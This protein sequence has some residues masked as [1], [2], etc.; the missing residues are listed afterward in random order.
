M[1]VCSRGWTRDTT[2]GAAVGMTLENF[3]RHN[4]TD[5]DSLLATHGL[6][7]EEA[8]QIV[9]GAIDVVL[10]SWRRKNDSTS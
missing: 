6:P 3:V 7:R 8:R 2:I 10:E 5:Y 4:L 9:R 1:R